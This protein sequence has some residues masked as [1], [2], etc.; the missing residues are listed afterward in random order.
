MRKLT[1]CSDSDSTTLEESTNGF[2]KQQLLANET[3]KLQCIA[4]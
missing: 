1:L 3:L 2:N 4:L